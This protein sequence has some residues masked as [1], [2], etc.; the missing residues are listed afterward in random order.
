MTPPAPAERVLHTLDI[1][2]RKAGAA[3]AAFG[4]AAAP[5]LALRQSA[6]REAA[7]SPVTAAE[8]IRARIRDWIDGGTSIERPVPADAASGPEPQL[9]VGAV[10]SHVDGWL[11][12]VTDADGPRLLCRLTDP[13][14]TTNPEVVALAVRASEGAASAAS[15]SRVGR[16]LTEI[17]AFLD[18]ERAAQDAGVGAVGSAIHSAAAVRIASLAARAP[19][20]RRTAV[21]RLAVSA[22]RAVE[23]SQTAG[24]ERLLR[25]LLAVERRS[26]TTSDADEAWLS[27]VIE[28]EDDAPNVA[29]DRPR[30]SSRPIAV[31]V[32]VPDRS[33][34]AE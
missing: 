33:H 27:R 25:A 20:H 9:V 2:R 5:L 30:A 10:R 18:A 1:L 29:P 23:H 3:S 12:L 24:R 4:E 8:V 19:A 16:A 13:R 28:L 7:A 34:A 11:A 17:G 32:F 21:S 6:S 14:P 22:R 15:P 31:V 26:G